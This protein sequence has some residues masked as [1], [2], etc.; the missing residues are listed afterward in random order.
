MQSTA[1]AKS[2]ENYKAEFRHIENT[3][4]NDTLLNLLYGLL[5]TLNKRTVIRNLL[6]HVWRGPNE[7]STSMQHQQHA[8]PTA[9]LLWTPPTPLLKHRA[10][11]MDNKDASGKNMAGKILLACTWETFPFLI[12]HTVIHI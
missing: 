11:P 3:S 5:H 6:S 1:Q 7:Q 10:L 9:H 12:K 8:T 2:A 4:I